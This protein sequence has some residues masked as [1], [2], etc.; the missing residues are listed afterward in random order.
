LKNT[1]W[2]ISNADCKKLSMDE[3]EFI[4]SRDFWVDDNFT[5]TVNENGELN[6][7]NVV[8]PEQTFGY[9]E[10]KSGNVCMIR[11][12]NLGKLPIKFGHVDGGIDLAGC[13]LTTLENL[14]KTMFGSLHL[15]GN[16]LTDYFMSIKEDD[17]HLWEN[18]Y[19][20]NII[21]EYPFLINL[22]KKYN[23]EDSLAPLKRLI[24]E[25]SLTKLYLE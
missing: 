13:G 18:L 8:T 21:K 12:E 14:P 19:W 16:D 24:N 17:F 1:I 22:A 15:Y 25:N 7:K 4:K 20:Y 2:K 6:I 11:G 10:V 9:Y 3:I 5:I 23:I